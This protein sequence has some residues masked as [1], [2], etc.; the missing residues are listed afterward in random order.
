MR[1]YRDNNLG[2]ELAAMSR[3]D[4]QWFDIREGSVIGRVSDR[5]CAAETTGERLGVRPENGSWRMCMSAHFLDDKARE[6]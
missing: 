3:A 2:E 5:M 4:A 6:D 1:L